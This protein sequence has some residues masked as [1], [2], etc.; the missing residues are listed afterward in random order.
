MIP[1]RL[2]LHHLRAFK[3][4]AEQLHFKKAAELLHITQPGLTRIIKKLEDDLQVNLFERSTRQVRLTPAGFLLLQEIEQ[5]FVHLERGI[6]LAQKAKF[7]D[8]GH[9]IIAYNDYAVQDV[10]PRTLEHFR[11]QYS[12]ITTDLLYMPTQQ[13]IQGLQQGSL[14]LGF[15]FAFSDDPEELGV[16]WKPVCRDDPIVL[17]QKDHPLAQEQTVR[18]ADLAHERFVVGSKTHWQV[19]RRYFYSLCRHAGFHPNSVQEAS[20]ITGIMSMVAAHIGIAILSQS[21]RKYVHRDLVAIDLDLSGRHP[22][23]FINIMW[24]ESNPNPRVPLF[25]Q[26]ISPDLMP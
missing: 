23:S 18:L 3:T 17:L 7:G 6:E 21:L 5:V 15:G 26:T 16:Q 13:Q 10:L 12:N 8:I 2:D 20:T 9:L 25:I 4:V 19:W 11:Q 22:Q 24:H 1:G 14:D